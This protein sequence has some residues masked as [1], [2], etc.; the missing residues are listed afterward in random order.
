MDYILVASIVWVIFMLSNISVGY[1]MY[2]LGLH[3]QIRGFT[4]K[5]NEANEEEELMEKV[6]KTLGYVPGSEF[7]PFA[8][9]HEPR[10]DYRDDVD[11]DLDED[12]D[13]TFAPDPLVPR[14]GEIVNG[15]S[16]R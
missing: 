5:F 3:G 11:E 7:D 13:E 4:K 14:G 12:D 1:V 10:Y 16:E 15:E 6:G 8:T 9:Q 2:R